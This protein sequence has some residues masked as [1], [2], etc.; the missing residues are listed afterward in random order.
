MRSRRRS[1][2]RGDAADIAREGVGQARVD[3]AIEHPSLHA[4]ESKPWSPSSSTR[5]TRV[6]RVFAR[7]AIASC[8]SRGA[9]KPIKQVPSMVG[10]RVAA[11]TVA[12]EHGNDLPPQLSSV[13][14]VGVLALFRGARG[15]LMVKPSAST[16]RSNASVPWPMPICMGLWATLTYH[17]SCPCV[18]W[19]WCHDLPAGRWGIVV[20]GWVCG[21]M[22]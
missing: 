3:F 1:P 10:T 6:M 5:T 4:F 16:V 17:Y 18:R 2:R 14:G 22:G 20:P 15:F 8:L 11:A 9:P 21:L 7:A 12:C 19:R 13:R